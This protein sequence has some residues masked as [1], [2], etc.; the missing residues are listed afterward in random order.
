MN[1]EVLEDEIKDKLIADLG[2]GI[3]VEVLPETIAEFQKV[4]EAPKLSV[5]VDGINFESIQ[6]VNLVSQPAIVQIDIAIQS[7]KRRG[8]QGI[9]DLY[10]QAKSSLLGFIPTNCHKIYFKDFIL[11]NYGDNDD[12]WFYSLK[13]ECRTIIVENF[14]EETTPRY[15]DVTAEFDN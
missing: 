9:F 15:T 13:M 8:P 12:I 14:T 6:S 4:Y 1:P 2:S 7:R 11:S 3:D 10:N 5:C